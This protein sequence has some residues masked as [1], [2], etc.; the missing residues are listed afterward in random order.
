MCACMHALCRTSMSMQPTVQ[1]TY[2]TEIN[3]CTK[4]NIILLT[5]AKKHTHAHDSTHIL[6][7][8]HAYIR[9]YSRFE[10]L[11]GPQDGCQQLVGCLQP[12]TC[13]TGRRPVQVQSRRYVCSKDPGVVSIRKH[14][15]YVC[16]YVPM[17]MYVCMY[18]RCMYKRLKN[19]LVRILVRAHSECGRYT[20]QI[21]V[22]RSNAQL[23]GH[24]SKLVWVCAVSWTNI[25]WRT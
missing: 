14:H 11:A 3:M 24:R 10:D 9:F 22:P 23:F 25:M 2:T 8:A 6:E 12:R 17:C 18:E 13:W 19:R 15:V 4:V 16:M 5:H 21:T 20:S 1:P 7:K